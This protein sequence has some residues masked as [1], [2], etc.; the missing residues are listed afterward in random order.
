MMT[1]MSNTTTTEIEALAEQMRALDI[2][3]A[4]YEGRATV[5]FGEY[6]AAKEAGNQAAAAKSVRDRLIKA[7][8]EG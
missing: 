1:L 8:V 6:L 7:G 3:R 2:E 4:E 5:A